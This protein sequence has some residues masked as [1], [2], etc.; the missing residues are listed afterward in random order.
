VNANVEQEQLGKLGGRGCLGTGDKMRYLCEMV[1]KTNNEWW[2]L[3]FVPECGTGGAYPMLSLSSESES[4]SMKTEI[5]IR[6]AV[7]FYRPCYQ[8]LSFLCSLVKAVLAHSATQQS[9]PHSSSVLSAEIVDSTQEPDLNC[10]I[11]DLD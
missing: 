11:Y 7:I 8:D 1:N 5:V 4:K 3:E 9:P 2:L 6:L 10:S